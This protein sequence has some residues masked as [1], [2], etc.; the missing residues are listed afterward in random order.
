IAADRL[1]VTQVFAFFRE[2]EDALGGQLGYANTVA[3]RPEH[4]LAPW[5]RATGAAA[6]DLG[7]DG[8]PK[9]DLDTWDERYFTRLRAF[10]G[11]AAAHD[12]VV[13]VDLFVNLFD[14]ARWP[15]SPLHPGGNVNGV[16][17][18]L[19]GAGE[20]RLYA[21][22]SV[23]DHERRLIRKLVTEANAFDNV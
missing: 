10:L 5:A 8:L 11:A 22:P 18:G 6:R 16:G 12:V 20:F 23:I 15:L 19:A 1:N 7:P 14:A 21:D 4:Y 13:E 9:F 3:P 2:P 17:A